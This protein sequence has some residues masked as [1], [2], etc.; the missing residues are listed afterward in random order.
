VRFVAVRFGFFTDPDAT[1][2]C[3]L[4]LRRLKEAIKN[5]KIVDAV[6]RELEVPTDG[7]RGSSLREKMAAVDLHIDRL[8]ADE[9]SVWY[10]APPAEVLSA[11]IFSA[12]KTAE[13]AAADLFSDVA[14]KGDLAGPI[15]SWLGV[16]GF[17]AY[18]ERPAGMPG[19]DVIGYQVGRLMTKPRIL[20]IGLEN[21]PG[22]LGPTLERMAAFAE[23]TH[24]TYL[25]C[26]P[27]LAAELL[28]AYVNEPQVHRWDA[29]ALR[30]KLAALGFGLLLV[31]GDA[32]SESL[33]PRERKPD[34]AKVM[35]SL[36]ARQKKGSAGP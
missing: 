26:T 17:K 24:A 16:T 3:Y 5:P 2:Y 21:E 7:A 14:G 11:A 35:E 20:G 23:H 13:G 18:N 30:N 28:V 6:I 4:R 31:E 15:T 1:R 8:R 27:A 33:A 22:Q 25:A 12:R 34:L 10:G 29:A 36:A 32:V 19:V 9:T